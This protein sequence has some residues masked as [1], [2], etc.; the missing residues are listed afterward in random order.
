MNLGSIADLICKKIG[1]TDDESVAVCKDFI[2]RRHELVYDRALWKDSQ[3]V[4]AVAVSSGQTHVTLPFEAARPL[5]AWDDTAGTPMD[6]SS[7][8]TAALLDV[9]SLRQSGWATAFAE[10]DSVGWPYD[11]TL[12]SGSASML[13]FINTGSAPVTVNVFGDFIF[14]ASG[15]TPTAVT[16]SQTITVP[17]GGAPALTQQWRNVVRMTKGQT[18]QPLLVAQTS[19]IPEQTWVWPSDAETAEFARVRLLSAPTAAFTLGVLAKKRMRQMRLDAD[20]PAIRGIDNAL[21]ALAEGDMLERGRQYA[22]AQA[23]QTEGMALIQLALD[24]EKNQ[25]ASDSRIVPVVSEW[26]GTQRD[27]Y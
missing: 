9:N 26:E 19:P 21:I 10:V 11:L 23:K 24:V 4:T 22:K 25:A 6:T 14:S 12:G 8:F 18:D 17:T 2:R 1:K 7:L 3:T 20:P 27:I 5:L 16:M 13:S 15:L